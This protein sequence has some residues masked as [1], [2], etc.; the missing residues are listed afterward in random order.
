[1]F[2]PRGLLPAAVPVDLAPQMPRGLLPTASP[3]GS[4][5][6]GISCRIWCWPVASKGWGQETGGPTTGGLPD[7]HKTESP[8]S[9]VGSAA[10]GLTFKRTTGR[11]ATTGPASKRAVGD[12]GSRGIGLRRVNTRNSKRGPDV[13]RRGGH[14]RANHQKGR[15]GVTRD[16][17]GPTPRLAVIQEIRLDRPALGT[18]RDLACT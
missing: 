5:H 3:K 14:R 9:K 15:S 11:A 18:Q 16:K 12:P 6:I 1:M 10:G 2:L 4:A 13:K 7:M 8:E 17:R